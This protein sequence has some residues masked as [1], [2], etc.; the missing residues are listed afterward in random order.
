MCEELTRLFI[1]LVENKVFN[2][3]FYIPGD[4]LREHRVLCQVMYA[5]KGKG[6]PHADLYTHSQIDA[7]KKTSPSSS[8]FSKTN[9][10]SCAPTHM[11]THKVL[12]AHVCT[13]NAQGTEELICSMCVNIRAAKALFPRNLWHG[14]PLSHYLMT[15]HSHN[16]PPMALLKI[17]WRPVC[18]HARVWQA[19]TSAENICF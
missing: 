7:H 4:Y 17:T 2:I 9:G 11:K 8:C 13:H 19:H 14:L 16:P 3:T 12:N 10:F 5:G 1:I 15:K 6:N 18:A